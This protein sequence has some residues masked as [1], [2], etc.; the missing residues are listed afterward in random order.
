MTRNE[1]RA[2]NRRAIR[3]IRVSDVPLPT[4]R[5]TAPK[6]YSDEIPA[7]MQRQTHKRRKPHQAWKQDRT[8]PYYWNFTTI[9]RRWDK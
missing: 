4:V 3:N 7:L 2:Q 6:I 9:D 8:S 5:Q 1:R